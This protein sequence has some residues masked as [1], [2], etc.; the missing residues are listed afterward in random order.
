MME[1]MGRKFDI[2]ALRKAFGESQA[3]FAQRFGV[4]Q[5]TIH[6]WEANGVPKRGP[7]RIVA[8]RLFE[9]LQ[10]EAAE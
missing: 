5:A 3:A 7:A 4:D 8:Q 9:S 1:N 2:R 6:R 10:R